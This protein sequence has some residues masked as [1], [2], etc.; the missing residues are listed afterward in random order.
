MEAEDPIAL[1]QTWLADAQV[2]EP[3]DAT[4]MAVATADARGRPSVRML[5]LKHV[6]ARGFVFYT[7][8]D[9][10]KC[11][12]L[13]QNPRAALCFHW[14]KAE[15]QVRVEGA[16][17]PVSADE[18]DAYFA[19]RPRLS[20]LGAWASK[21]SQP[22]RGRFELEAAVAAMAARFAVGAVP[23]PPHWSGWRVRPEKIE[24]WHQRPFRHHDRRVFVREDDGWRAEWLFP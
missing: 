11:A 24:F 13:R 22:M 3:D 7:S 12:D 18:A 15:R 16:V 4:A 23:R 21:Q 1:F 17:D 14:A 10:P 5:L 6:D 2:S 9:S 20:Q 19:T 8:L